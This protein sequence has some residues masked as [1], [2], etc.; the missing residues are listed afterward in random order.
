[1]SN[2]VQKLE[3]GGD[4]PLVGVPLAV[5]VEEM[6]ISLRLAIDCDGTGTHCE[7]TVAIGW[8]ERMKKRGRR[9]PDQTS[10]ETEGTLT[11]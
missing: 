4:I 9:T 7:Q 11:I 8:R 3:E 6:G 1:M 2:D 5:G 10:Y